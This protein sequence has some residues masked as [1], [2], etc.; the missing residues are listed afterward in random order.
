[1][2]IKSNGII[3]N[4]RRTNERA[5]K[6]Q[7]HS[8]NWQLNENDMCFTTPPMHRADKDG[9][10]TMKETLGGNGIIMTTEFELDEARR[11]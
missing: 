5:K 3:G 2:E 6:G 1:V 4:E 7:E 9:S 10:S 11:L 8:T